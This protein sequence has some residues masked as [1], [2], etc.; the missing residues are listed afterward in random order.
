MSTAEDPAATVARLLKTQMRVILGNDALASVNVSSEYPNSYALKA[1]DGQVTVAL[2]E[3]SDQKLD[4]SGK[5]RRRTQTVRVNVWTTDA[6]GAEE[7][8]QSIR[9]RIV[10]AVNVA[11][12]QN[13]TIPNETAYTY[14]GL[15][16]ASHGSR[17]FSGKAEAAPNAVWNELSISDY[18][19]LWYSDDNRIQIS[20]SES[21]ARSVLLF[22]F[23]VDSHRETVKKTVFTFEGYGSAP[24]A[25]GVTAKVW[26][27]NA[28]AWQGSVSNEEN[29]NDATLTLPVTANLPDFI[30]EDG[31]LWFLAETNGTSD[32]AT[33]AVLHCDWASCL[34]TVN[35]VTYCDIAGYRNLDRYDVKP[36]IYRT[37]FTVKTWLIEN[38]GV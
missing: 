28:A 20:A 4:L 34:V 23:K 1:G 27:N 6:S 16:P 36:P 19:K 17:A 30:D 18:E 33:P 2:A 14:V 26:N 11:I 29:Q 9:S 12:R 24:S 38:I 7:T 15:G 22:G 13:R 37:E 25:G 32:G 31:Y 10:E 5:T 3:S 8:G 21:G 35:G